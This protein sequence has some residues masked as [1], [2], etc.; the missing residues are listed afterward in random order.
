IVALK[1]KIISLVSFSFILSINESTSRSEGP[2]PSIGEI[3]PPK[4]WYTPLYWLVFS[5]AITSRVSSTTQ[6]ILWSRLGEAHI[7]QT[8]LS[9][10]FKQTRQNCISFGSLL[11]VALNRSTSILS[12]LIRCSTKRK[13]V[14]WPTPGSLAN[15]AT[16]SSRSFEEKFIDQR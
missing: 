4:T 5:I 7:W 11:M 12:W 10:I 16:A 13:A 9:D 6:I 2:I 3:K 8:G 15:S 14:F 1:A